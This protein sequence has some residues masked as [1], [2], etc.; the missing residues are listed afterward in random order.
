MIKQTVCFFL[1]ILLFIASINSAKALELSFFLGLKDGSESSDGVVVRFFVDEDDEA[2]NVFE[3]LWEQQQ[4]SDEF[5]VD[6]TEWGTRNITLNLTTDP[7]PAR[8]TG[9]DWILIGDAKI[10]DNGGVVYDIGQVV[11]DGEAKLSMLLDGEKK[12]T[13]GLDFGANCSPDTGPCGGETKSKSF[14]Q[15]PPW[16]GRVG[17]TISRYE[18]Q[19]PAAVK[20]D[21]KLTLTWGELKRSTN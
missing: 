15:H 12:E 1:V 9:W 13:E 21:G 5:V 6:L 11:A 16:D 18:M 19:L 7:G 4:W 2:T 8:N 10:T 3:Q 20:A 14:M 17:N